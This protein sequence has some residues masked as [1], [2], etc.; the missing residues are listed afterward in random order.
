MII[1][2]ADLREWRIGAVMY[3]WFLRHFP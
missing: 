2:R 3:R 1:T